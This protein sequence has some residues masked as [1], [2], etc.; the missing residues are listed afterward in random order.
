MREVDWTIVC[1]RRRLQEVAD[2]ERYLERTERTYVAALDDGGWVRAEPVPWWANR[3]RLQ[4]GEWRESA[5][6]QG[7]RKAG[8]RRRA[9]LTRGERLYALAAHTGNLRTLW[10][11][12]SGRYRDIMQRV[13]AG[14]MG[15]RVG[16]GAD[17]SEVT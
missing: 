12:G 15:R 3:S 8:A 11:A 10:V 13:Q 7:G 9:C 16:E 4:P 17:V 14:G 1:F 6:T 5:P 2:F